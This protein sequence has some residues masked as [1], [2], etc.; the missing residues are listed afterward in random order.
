MTAFLAITV[1][2]ARDPESRQTSK[3]GDMTTVFAFGKV[4]TRDDEDIDYPISLLAFGRLASELADHAKGQLIYVSGRLELQRY[5]GELRQSLLLD[6]LV[7]AQR[8][9]PRGGRKPQ[10]QQ[11]SHKE[12]IREAA[13]TY[14]RNHQSGNGADQPPPPEAGDPG[15]GQYADFEDRDI[16]F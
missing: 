2:L 9:K 13:D 8:L 7:S 10:G 4:D 15:P 16:P 14:Q 6:S 11:G 3:G 5:N 12:R 1:R